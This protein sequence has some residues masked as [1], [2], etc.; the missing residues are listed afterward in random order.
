MDQ[1]GNKYVVYYRVPAQAHARFGFG[2]EPQ[3]IAAMVFLE[4]RR[5][6]LAAEYIE[7]EDAGQGL[8]PKLVEALAACAGQ[9][10][11]LFIPS[12]G[13]LIHDACFTETLLASGV[14]VAVGDLPRSNLWGLHQ[15]VARA[16]QAAEGLLERT[17]TALSHARQAMGPAGM[18][19]PLHTSVPGL[20][21]DRRKPTAVHEG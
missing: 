20:S 6:V 9:G 7:V 19:P 11:E 18:E 10:A 12:L 3:R 21:A 4:S 16:R 13:R 2:L 14:S 1:G 17:R 15:E 8:R 5:G